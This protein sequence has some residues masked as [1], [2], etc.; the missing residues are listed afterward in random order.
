MKVTFHPP[1]SADQD[2]VSDAD[3]MVTFDATK[4]GLYLLSAAHQ[5]ETI[6]GFF[7]GKPYDVI[8]HNCSL[9]WRQP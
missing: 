5:R 4:P 6:A 3:G 2:L 8:S 1:A 7:G 9:A